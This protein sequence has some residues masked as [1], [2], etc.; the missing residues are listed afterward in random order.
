MKI[1]VEAIAV[2]LVSKNSKSVSQNC[3]TDLPIK[4]CSLF[5]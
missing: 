3:N 5:D 4:S 1:L 2:V